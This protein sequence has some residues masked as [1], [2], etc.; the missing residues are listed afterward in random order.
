MIGHFPLRIAAAG[1]LL[2]A[3][4]VAL[5]V[6]EDRARAAGR[7]VALPMEAFD[8]RDLLTGHYV[9]LQMTQRLAPGRPCPTRT[10]PFDDGG[11][12]A[13]R[14]ADGG[15]VGQ[16]DTREAAL[17]SGGDLAVRGGV[18][19]TRMMVANVE[20]NAVTLDVGVDRF[21]ADQAEAEAMEKVLRARGGGQA[22]PAFA[23]V[24]V[25]EDGRARLK[26]VILDGKRTD[27]TWW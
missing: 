3:M 18:L 13:L 12:L 16:G 19:C 8:P 17:A 4:L 21:H 7:E 1:L 15:F 26:G 23:V 24:S 11:W 9:A 27:L 25:G 5:V 14:A 10:Q 22:V 20:T 2:T 6:T